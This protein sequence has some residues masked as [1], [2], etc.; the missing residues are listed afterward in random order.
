MLLP[1][2]LVHVEVKVSIDM[3]W[4]LGPEDKIFTI[5]ELVQQLEALEALPRALADGIS[6]LRVIGVGLRETQIDPRNFL[7]TYSPDLFAMDEDG[8]VTSMWPRL[9][10]LAEKWTR[11]VSWWWVQVENEGFGETR[12]MVEVWREVGETA[13]DLI[14]RDDYDARKTLEGMFDLNC[15]EVV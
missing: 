13:R 3:Y 15:A 1:L 6:T 2:H 4:S 11:D 7:E 10:R 5:T 12:H 8:G 14:R 9:T